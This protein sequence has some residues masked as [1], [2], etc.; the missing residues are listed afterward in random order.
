MVEEFKDRPDPDALLKA[1]QL[2]ELNRKKGGLKIFLGMA[3]GVGK[4]YSMLK[5]A[6]E[7]NNTGADL[8]VGVIDTHDRSET[9]ALLE[10]LKVLPPKEI[11]YRG[12]IFYELDVDR[13]LEL[14][15]EIV[16][17]DELA[18]NNVPGSKHAKRWQD[19]AELLDHGIDVYTTLNVQHIESLNDIVR[20]ITEVNVQE[21]VPDLLIEK[22]VSIQLVDL[23]PDEL[24]QRLAEGK[25]YLGTQSRVAVEN[26]FQVNRLTA[27]REVVL[28]YV[29]DKVDL[30]LQKMIPSREGMVEWRP[31]EKFLVA[32]SATPHAQKLIRTARRLASTMDASWLAVHVD[33]G[34]TLSKN[35]VEQL[36]KNIQL[37][38]DLGGEVVMV[39]DPDIPEGIR[40]VATQ[41]GIT[42]IILGRSPSRPLDF[43]FKSFSL[44]NQLSSK[45]KEID[46]HVI[47]QEKHTAYFSKS[48]FKIPALGSFI[49]YLFAAGSVLLL[50]VMNFF[51]VPYIG[52]EVVGILYLLGIL[53]LSLFFKMGPLF[54]GALLSAVLWNFY[55]MTPVGS[56]FVARREDLALLALFF[57]TAITTGVLVERAYAHRRLL[58]K[59]ESTTLAL[60]EIVHTLSENLSIEQ[61]L[62]FVTDRVEKEFNSP[63]ELL[64]KKMNDGLMLKDRKHLLEK[65]H[66]KTA[67][68]WSF[69]NG[70]EA[71]W[72]TDTLPSSENLY[73]PL[74]G[75]HEVVGVLVFHSKTGRMLL[76]EE[77]SFL[78]AIA[79]QIGGFIERTFQVEKTR[80]HDQLLQLERIHRTIL[81]RFSKAFEAPIEEMKNVLHQLQTPLL[82]KTLPQLTQLENGFQSILEILSKVSSMAQLSEGMMPVRKEYHDLSEFVQ[83]CCAVEEKIAEGHPVDIIT[84][85]GLPPVAF[86]ACLLQ[87]LF[88]NIFLNAVEHSPPG[89]RI[90]VEVKREGDFYV[91]SITDEGKGVPEEHL[92]EIFEPFYRAPDATSPGIGLGLAISRTIALSHHAILKAENVKGKGARFSLFLPEG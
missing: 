69:E 51:L 16:L 26:F 5:A 34:K 42:Q 86:D 92:E 53:I 76:V 14:S 66:E 36:V 56:I 41:R 79:Q 74:K 44:L 81:F 80:Q 35:E 29:A 49:E 38:R 23:T 37:A 68:I 73:L 82:R 52:Y 90:E 58:A 62:A 27:L 10:G 28:R 60:Y 65:E 67:A 30:D 22:A 78:Y 9:A 72:S 40:R 25:V 19:V 75:P 3:A 13:I 45:C 57:V 54:F 87:I 31:R 77:K 20:S 8:L 64:I 46:I 63:C 32:V 59:S 11:E 15:P 1:I 2:D 43:L 17:V 84:E 48:R 21:T 39:S 85:S 50:T 83:N 55:F 6:H 61:A 88:H 71:G 24:L 7:I 91:L 70:K 33:D 4:T 89:G 47:R 18:H 12:K